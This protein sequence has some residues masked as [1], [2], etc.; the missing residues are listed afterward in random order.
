MAEV[1]WP[2]CLKGNWKICVALVP[3]LLKTGLVSL[4]LL[5]ANPD[6]KLGSSSNTHL[7]MCYQ[8]SCSD[9]NELN[10]YTV[11]TPQLNA[12]LLKSCLIKSAN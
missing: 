12:L 1:P 8:A 2:W 7:P 9:D 11:N 3:I 6:E 5:P 10:L 4:F